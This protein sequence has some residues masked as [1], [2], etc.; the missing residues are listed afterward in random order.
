MELMTTEQR[1]SPPRRHERTCVGC[2]R[3]DAPGHLVRVVVR[4]DGSLIA[5]VRGG[6]PGR[7]AHVHPASECIGRAAKRGLARSFRC[8]VQIEPRVLADA[9]VQAAHARAG[10]MI[11]LALLSG[12]AVV[13]RERILLDLSRGALST[14][15]IA[16]DAPKEALL[17]GLARAIAEGNAVAWGTCASLGALGRREP[18]AVLGIRSSTLGDAIVQACRVA[19]GARTGAEVR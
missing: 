7:G 13:E 19:D 9:I 17:G 18:V 11:S 6:A 2:G 12:Q 8:A 14:V 4:D 3:R 10:E 5:D 16:L 1:T 15:V